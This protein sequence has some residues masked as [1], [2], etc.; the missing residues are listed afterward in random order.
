[1][2]QSF[3]IFNFVG[4]PV[5]LSIWFFLLFL[6][7][8]VSWVIGLF[9][10]I[11]VHEMAHAY[12]ADKLGW[13]VRG[14]H[15]DLF[16]GSAAVDT[17]IHERDSIKVVAAGPLSNLALAT[18]G[19][20]SIFILPPDTLTL[21]RDFIVSFITINILLF[22]FNILPIF[23]MDG[24][25]ILRDTLY[26]KTKSRRKS[27]RISAVVSLITT[28]FVMIYAISTWSIILLLFCLLFVYNSL[29]ELEV[30]K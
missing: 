2:K 17:N 10:S 8:P 21:V 19:F 20:L 22:L 7:L 11:L 6:F 25:R 3:K 27:L 14:I 1:M 30:I 29:K 9:I 15:I 18:V 26:L 12:V 4:S 23:P 13:V 16:S 28:I 5:E 24:G